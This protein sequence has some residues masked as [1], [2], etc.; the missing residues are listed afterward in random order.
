MSGS[1][2]IRRAIGVRL[3]HMPMTPERVRAALRM[4]GKA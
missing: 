4:A 1:Y 2:A 3:T